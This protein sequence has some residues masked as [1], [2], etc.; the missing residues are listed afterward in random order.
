MLDPAGN[1]APGA[2]HTYQHKA[3]FGLKAT[4]F[5]LPEKENEAL[6]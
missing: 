2:I 1:T 6:E 5:D 4:T 3:S